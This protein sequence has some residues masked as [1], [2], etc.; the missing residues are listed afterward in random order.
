[1]MLRRRCQCIPDHGG[2]NQSSTIVSCFSV[3]STFLSC[4]PPRAKSMTGNSHRARNCPWFHRR[5]GRSE[6]LRLGMHVRSERSHSAVVVYSTRA[7]T[8][9]C[10]QRNSA[11]S[12]RYFEA[13]LETDTGSTSR[14]RPIAGHNR[15]KKL[16]N[17]SAFRELK[18]RTVMMKRLRNV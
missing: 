5:A 4:H 7:I 2:D 8:V 16:A 1:M 6:S 18:R 13:A 15:G 14:C 10:C 11:F 17:I 3:N 12:R 9:R